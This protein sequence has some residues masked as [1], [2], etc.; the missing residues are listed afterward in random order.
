MLLAVNYTIKDIFN[1]EHLITAQNEDPDYLDFVKV[2]DKM[3]RVS[4]LDY[5]MIICFKGKTLSDTL[6]IYYDTFDDIKNKKLTIEY[7]TH[8]E[9]DTYKTTPVKLKKWIRDYMTNVISSF[10]KKR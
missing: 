6:S 3:A 7:L 9:K 8:N 4:P 10:D 5:A 2:I 1:K